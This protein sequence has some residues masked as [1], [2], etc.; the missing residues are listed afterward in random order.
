VIESI[1]QDGR[2]LYKADEGLRKLASVDPAAVFQL[3]TFLQ[4]VVARGTAARISALSSYVGGKTGT[5]DDFNDA[6]FAGFSND[7][8]IVVWMGYDNAKGKR[9]LGNGQAGGKVALPIFASIIKSVWAQGAPQTPLPRPSPE[10]ARHLIAL[11]I[12]VNSG[13]RVDNRG[14]IDYRFDVRGANTRVSGGFM[15]Y[16][17]VDDSGR[18]NDT[19]DRLA[20]RGNYGGS[21]G[22]DGSSPFFFPGGNPF[23]SWFGRSEGPP[24]F[25]PRYNEGPAYVRPPVDDRRPTRHYSPADRNGF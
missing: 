23:Q 20:S 7:V 12:D 24:S 10:A 14:G 8:T 2:E 18:L 17:R 11:P 19:Q 13:Q 9:T 25:G 16:F 15:E 3:R 5:S 4:G 6:W 22:E 1:T 21:Y